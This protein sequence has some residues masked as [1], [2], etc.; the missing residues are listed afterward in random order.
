MKKTILILCI[1][2]ISLSQAQNMDTESRSNIDPS[3]I[4]KT[5]LLETLY[6]QSKQ[7]E[8]NP[9]TTVQDLEQ[10]RLAIINAWMEVNPEIATL[11]KPVDNG[12]KLPE[13]EE[14]IHIN[15]VFVPTE[16]KHRED[17][18][19][20]RDW[21]LDNL[22]LDD[23]VDGGIDMEVTH[24]G[25]IYISHYKNDI[26]FGGPFDII[27]VH[28]SLDGGNTFEL[29]KTANIT[30]PVTRAKL[31]SIDGPGSTWN[32]I[33]VYF[34]TETNNFQVLKWGI[35][36]SSFEATVIAS[37]VNYFDVDRNFNS[38]T[39]LQRVFAVYDKLSTGGCHR[40][41]SARST[42][43][44]YGFN[45]V[46]EATVQNSCSI[47]VSVAYGMNGG[48]Y[49]S[50]RG[51]TSN[52]LYYNANSNYNDPASWSARISIET[53]PDF[54]TQEAS[55]IAE[56]F[57]APNDVAYIFTNSQYLGDNYLLVYPIEN[58]VPLA[59]ASILN[60]FTDYEFRLPDLW[61]KKESGQ[62]PFSYSVGVE[63][64]GANNFVF[65]Q[66]M[67][68]VGE[69]VS[70]AVNNIFSSISTAV[71]E[72]LD[73]LPCVAFSGS[74]AG[75]FPGRG[76]YFDAETELL[77]TVDNN[78]DK[79]KIFPNPALNEINFQASFA[80]EKVVILNNLGQIIFDF[81][82]NTTSFSYDVSELSSGMYYV[83]VTGNNFTKTEKII[84][85]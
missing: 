45:W 54:F 85:K 65:V 61:I 79:L 43:G 3:S 59:L 57:E 52:F 2:F 30:A 17:P 49:T 35:E 38:N 7:L 9:Q 14:N 82:P 4:Q 19:P 78:L 46:D 42:N 50:H 20:T 24:E 29:W 6:A 47:D 67:G 12:G 22:L 40:I 15:G 63:A 31:I 5:P 44:T 39:D 51:Q 32:Y 76:L 28:R 13:I 69:Q 58:N 37:T 66:K 55:I 36:D 75:G 34:L 74:G 41:Y 64:N 84:K 33:N 80:I 48:V 68:E 53:D 21:G 18:A 70:D 60:G 81:H 77:G 27:Y 10:N 83:K 56:R 26:V 73:G 1:A 23:W 8:E 11:Y 16:I 72:T 71:A 62:T 25:H